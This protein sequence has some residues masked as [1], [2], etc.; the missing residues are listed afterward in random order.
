MSVWS[1]YRAVEEKNEHSS[2]CQQNSV[3]TN[4]KLFLSS[5]YTLAGSSAGDSSCV[6]SLFD[7]KNR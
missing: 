2:V 3:K 4:L 6:F 5:L 1:E 7:S